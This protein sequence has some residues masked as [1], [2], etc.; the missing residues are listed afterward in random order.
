MKKIFAK[1]LTTLVLSLAATAASAEASPQLG[2]TC[3]AQVSTSLGSSA[4]FNC[5]H[6]PGGAVTIQLIYERGFRVVAISQGG[7]PGGDIYLSLI[8]EQG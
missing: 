5:Q 1:T 8:I 3:W 7:R 4:Q 2:G 6:L